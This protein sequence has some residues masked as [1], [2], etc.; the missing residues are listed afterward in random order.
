MELLK[1]KSKLNNLID[2]SSNVLIMGHKYLDLD[3]ISSSIGVYEYVKSR[4]KKATIIINDIKLEK[5]VK[6]ALDKLQDLYNI[7]RSSHI[8][9]EINK[10]SLVIVVDTN[11]EYL[12]QDKDLFNSIDNV[13]VIDHH[14]PTEYSIKKG[15]VIID[16]DASS[17]CEMLTDL[18]KGQVIYLQNGEL[19]LKMYNLY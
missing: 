4:N 7:K 9:K 18:L 10:D 13:A 16:R 12:L 5:G 6:R 14:D 17:T 2:K 11:K 19:V 3:A 8:N 15:L 1:Y